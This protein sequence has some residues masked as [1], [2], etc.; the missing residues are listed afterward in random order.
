MPKK[1][2]L[3]DLSGYSTVLVISKAEGMTGNTSKIVKSLQKDHDAGVIITVNQP[4]PVLEKILEKNGVKTDSLYFIDCISKTA[5]GGSEKSKKCL[6]VNSPSDLTE[7]SIA[8]MQAL[9]SFGDK[10]KFVFIDS[11]ATFLMYNS[12]GTLSKFSHF[13]ITK[14]SL[15]DV[16]GIFMSVEE[17]MDEKLINELKSFCEKT[18]TLK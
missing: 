17:E 10:K 18:I 2:G 5:G 12:A 1:T 9:E 16:S 7:L 14:I 4:Y 15:M 11:L 3:E 8:I 13:L 6:Y